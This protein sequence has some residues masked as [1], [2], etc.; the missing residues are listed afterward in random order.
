MY[1]SKMQACNCDSLLLLWSNFLRLHDSFWAG[2]SINREMFLFVL[3]YFIFL[4]H[5][6]HICFILIIYCD[7][8]L[9][10]QGSEEST[11][12]Q[13]LQLPPFEFLDYNKGNHLTIIV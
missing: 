6:I 2:Y 11:E 10:Y 5:N 8:P 1:H 4:F 9:L 13:S 7:F 12:S 3:F